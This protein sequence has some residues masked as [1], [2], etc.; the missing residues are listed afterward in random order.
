MFFWFYL[1]LLTGKT[2]LEL[3]PG[4][5]LH[6]KHIAKICN[7]DLGVDELLICH[8]QCPGFEHYSGEYR[9]A[10]DQLNYYAEGFNFP[11]CLLKPDEKADY[12][13]V[14]NSNVRIAYVYR[15]PLDQAVSF[16]RH[17]QNHKDA[18]HRY[19]VD[20]DGEQHLIEDVRQ[21]VL[22]VGLE[23]YIKQFFTFKVVKQMCPHN[24]LMLKYE[25]L[26]ANPAR[27]FAAILYHFGHDLSNPSNQQKI[28]QALALSCKDSIKRIEKTL[29]H[30]L[31]GDQAD[32]NESH[33]R[34]G[35]VG[36]WTKH[37]NNDD[38]DEIQKRLARFGLSLADFD[39]EYESAQQA[40]S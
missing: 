15:N 34:G 28:V 23:S 31:V 11:N 16:F 17:I 24:L 30:S 3:R 25:T 8:N 26:T 14:L 10:W 37:L 40:V 7:I 6:R 19:Y 21:Y 22:N 2:D 20:S 1:Q 18:R 29:G 4:G 12:D 9:Q 36:K 13:P 32:P 35:E 5:L 39:V 38:L 33:V 27:G